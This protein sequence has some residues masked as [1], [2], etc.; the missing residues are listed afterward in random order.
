MQWLCPSSIDIIILMIKL[1]NIVHEFIRFKQFIIHYLIINLCAF[2]FY[3][4]K[5][6]YYAAKELGLTEMN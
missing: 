2:I 1:H 3:G 4:F 5:I 6:T